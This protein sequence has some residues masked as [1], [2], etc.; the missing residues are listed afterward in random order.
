MCKRTAV[1]IGAGP[2]LGNHIAAEFGCEG[3]RVVLIA[4][5][6]NVLKGYVRELNSRGI[7]ADYRV[8]DCSDNG[9]IKSAISDIQKNYGCVDV[10][11]YNAIS[12]RKGTP[13]DLSPEELL[14]RYQVDVVGALC[15]SQQVIPAMKERK[16]GTILFTGGGFALDPDPNFL[17][18]S[19]NKAA[20]RSLAV[21]M[22]KELADDGIFVGIVNIKG[23]IGSDEK[24]SP[25]NVAKLF[26]RMYERRD[27]A[28]M[29]Y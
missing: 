23:H 20:L 22:N 26:Y 2:G 5:R 11:L 13:I 9:S 12:E 25:E 18:V 19:V 7:E 1:I 24:Y 28:E 29:T 16:N 8:A 15:A 27:T 3:F 10:L 17:S 21:A 4:R 6:E 14:E